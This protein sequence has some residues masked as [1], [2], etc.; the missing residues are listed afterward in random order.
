[1]CTHKI[2]YIH[3]IC[4]KFSHWQKRAICLVQLYFLLFLCNVYCQCCCQKCAHLFY[5]VVCMFA[6]MVHY[7]G[8]QLSQGSCS[9][10]TLVAIQVISLLLTCVAVWSCQ[11]HMM[12][13]SNYG[14]YQSKVFS[15]QSWVLMWGTGFGLCLFNPKGTSAVLVLLAITKCLHFMCLIWNGKQCG[16][17]GFDY[18]IRS[19]FA[20]KKAEVTWIWRDLHI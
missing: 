6:G 17:A 13:L 20:S 8:G 2:T 7:V 19:I 18:C 9:S 4:F 14:R 3:R 15:S 1:M 16:N 5:S 11:A 12:R 10:T